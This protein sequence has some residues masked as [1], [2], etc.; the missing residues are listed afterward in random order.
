MLLRAHRPPSSPV[1]VQCLRLP[2][3]MPT[4][5]RIDEP[6]EVTGY[7]F[8]NYAYNASDTIRVAPLIIALEPVWKPRA[9]AD[10]APL[11]THG[12][13]TLVMLATAAALVLAT[14]VGFSRGGR[15]MPGHRSPEPTGLDAALADVKPFSVE[16]SL[17]D[18]ARQ[19]RPNDSPTIVK[20]S[21]R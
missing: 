4:G 21:P 20:E 14:W 17:R 19:G 11:A 15:P 8:K 9:P 13:V 18:L 12:G 5:M 7:F 16:E 3:G 10:R 1:V 2:D 6:V